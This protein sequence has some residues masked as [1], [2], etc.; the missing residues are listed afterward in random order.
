MDPIAYNVDDAARV[1]GMS[2][3][4]IIRAIKAGDLKAKRT[5]RS[6]TGEPAGKFIILRRELEAF[7]ENLP[8]DWWGAK[9]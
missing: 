8:D 2:R 5:S 1:S 6:E 3:T 7:L 4:L 9:Y